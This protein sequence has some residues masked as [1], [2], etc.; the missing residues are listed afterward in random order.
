MASPGQTNQIAK[1]REPAATNQPEALANAAK[2][3][4]PRARIPGLGS[5]SMTHRPLSCQTLF[6]DRP[7][8]RLCVGDAS[9]GTQIDLLAKLQAFLILLHENAGQSV[10]LHVAGDS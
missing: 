2:F 9:V 10:P 1:R 5:R 6:L 3:T 4:A 7:F 8:P